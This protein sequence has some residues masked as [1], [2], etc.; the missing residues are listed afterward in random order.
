MSLVAS[1]DREPTASASLGQVHSA[2]LS[3]RAPRR[4]EG[5][6][7]RHRPHR[8]PRSAH[9]PPHPRHRAVA[10]CPCR[11]WTRTTT[12]SRSCS[13]R[14]STS[15][16]KPTT[17][18]ASRSNFKSNPR[19]V[20]PRPVRELCTQRVLTTDVARGSEGERH[21]RACAP[22]ASTRKTSPR[23]WC[24][25]YC[26]MIFVDGVYHADPHPGNVLVQKD[27]AIV[28]LDFGAVAVLSPADARGHPRVPRGR[29]PPRHRPPLQVDAQDGLHLA[30]G[31]DE[32]TSEKIIEYFHRR[33]QEEVRLE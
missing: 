28:L 23:A 22:W 14:S 7:P 10:S 24:S 2:R 27:G 12:R 4:R 9:H 20:F 32:A 13:R 15:C 16:S 11:A 21:R 3:R 1:L 33:F 8:A 6:A 25:L 29:A 19:V 18:S 30:H 31:S 17:S 26:Q 5:P